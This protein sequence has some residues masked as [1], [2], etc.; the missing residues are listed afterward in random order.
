ML[1]RCTNP[2]NPNFKHYGERGISVCAHWHTFANFLAD[3]GLRPGRQFSLDRY[4]DNDGNY[5]PGNVRWAT[6][7]EQMKN[8]RPDLK[9]KAKKNLARGNEVRWG[10][11]EAA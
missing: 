2:R 4:P 10:K 1:Q 3:V 8:I 6:R 11:K 9:E 7:S 5:E